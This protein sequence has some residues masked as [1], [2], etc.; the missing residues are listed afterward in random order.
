[1]N[2]PV[3]FKIFGFDIMWY[4]VL[5]G[6][7]IILAF[8]LAYFNS[9]RKGLKFENLIDIFLIAFPCAIIG[10]RVYYVIFEWS[11]YKH[12]F[13]DI[14]NIRQ[15]GLAIHGGLIGAFLAAFIYTK[16]KKINFLAYA[17]LVAPSIILAQG[18]G[19]W[20]NFMNSEAHGG[21]VSKEFISKFPLFIQRGMFIDGEYYHPTFLYE[22]IWDLLVC[23][24][25]VIILYKVKKGYEGIVISSYMILYSLGRFFI[26]G[27]RTDSLMFFGFRIAQLISFAGIILGIIFIIIIIRKNKERM[28]FG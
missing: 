24:V 10:A 6:F 18:I 15:G 25:L 13:I 20:G 4:G 9:K 12:N 28:I 19:R 1:M 17:D 2:D 11:N 16:I 26:E 27:L 8:I 7:G 23:I 14:F 21:L 5:I 22:S 3:A